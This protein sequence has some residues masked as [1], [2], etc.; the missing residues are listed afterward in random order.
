MATKR[1]VVGLR[2]YGTEG[3]ACTLVRRHTCTLGGWPAAW[4]TAPDERHPRGTAPR[5]CEPPG[6]ATA[7]RGGESN[8]EY[9]QYTV[10]SSATVIGRA[11]SCTTRQRRNVY[12]CDATAATR[13]L[14]ASQHPSDRFSTQNP[15]VPFQPA[16]NH[17]ST[18]RPPPATIY[19]PQSA[20]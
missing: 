11:N 18:A 8:G 17:A 1:L 5:C 9:K 2:A 20:D 19:H 7:A 6:H 15:G 4:R 13:H 10:H 14:G 3:S 16:P 12:R